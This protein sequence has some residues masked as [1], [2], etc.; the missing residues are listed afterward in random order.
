MS[1]KKGL[2]LHV[3]AYKLIG[4][5]N[6]RGIYN[7][8]HLLPF[9]SKCLLSF[10]VPPLSNGDINVHPYYLKKYIIVH[11]YLGFISFILMWWVQIQKFE[12][13]LLI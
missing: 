9:T 11:S 4:K 2:S 6:S 7:Y 5:Q 12:F 3:Y 10:I 13:W 1:C 8:W